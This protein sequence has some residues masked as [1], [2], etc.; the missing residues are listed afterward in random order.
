M[1]GTDVA[2][3]IR[4]TFLAFFSRVF[5]RTLDID[6]QVDAS[7]NEDYVY[8]DARLLHE[9]GSHRIADLRNTPRRIRIGSRY[10]R[11][12]HKNLHTLRQLADWDPTFDP[13][14]GFAFYEKDVPEIL[15]YLRSKASVRFSQRAEQISVENRPLEYVHDVR[16]TAEG[17]GIVTSLSDPD[18][19]VRIENIDQAKFLEGSKFV[20]AK[21][22]YFRNPPKKE[23]KTFQPT[24]GT[25]NL[26]GDQIPLFLLYDLKKLR[27]ETT[28]RISP[29]VEAQRVAADPFEAKVSLHVDGPWIW[30]DVRYQADRFKIPYGQVGSLPPRQQ[31]MR[32]EEVWVQVDRKTHQNVAAQFDQIPEVERVEGQF[33]TPT[34]HFNEVQSL[35][36][37]VA[38]LDL[39]EAY[40][41]FMKSLEDFTQ[42]QE[43]P[44]PYGF[45]GE[46]RGYQ[47]HG[48]DWLCFLRHYGLN[49]ILA[50]EMGLGKTVQAL[51]GL[52]ESHSLPQ[53]GT[54][55]IV[56]PPTV[57]SAWEEEIR[58]FISPVDFSIARY[59]GANRKA[60]LSSL[61]HYDAI[62]TTYNIVVRDI[63]ALA[64]VAWEYVI[65][66][67]A[68][69]IKNHETATANAC[70]RLIARHKLALT[71][72]PI[73]NRLS[74][75]W[76]I[77][78]FLMPSYLGGQSQ[79]RDKYEVPIMKYSDKRAAT[80]L[81]R[82]IG[83][84]K[85]RRLK[86]QVAS[87]LPPKIPM[88]RYCEL[89]PEQ[90]HLYKQF[91]AA[92]SEKIRNL[93][94][95]TIRIDTSILTA[96]LR[97]KQICC[98]PALV[99]GDREKIHGRSGKLEA[100]LEILDELTENG[101]KALIFSQ[102]TEMLAILRQVLDEKGVSYFYLD[103][104]TPEKNR[105]RM[106]EDFQRGALPFFL[107]S[108]RAGGLGLTLTEAN[109]VVHY[110]RWWN[111][112]VEDQATDRVHRI[113]QSKP[114]KVFRIH[115]LGTIEERIGELLVKKKDLF[116]SV[117]EADDLRKEISKDELLALFAP[118]N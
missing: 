60:V 73:E 52:L 41:T 86:S 113:G 2:H 79:F 83:P 4:D 82:R 87:E 118:P 63:D 117:I 99:L 23:Y 47:K 72:T 84:F 11:I 62:L 50:D 45:R 111:P 35:L 74:E 106:K 8:V 24:P 91:A 22:G 18:S 116:D 61:G 71:G 17:L 107:I 75:L 12:S 76:S 7:P 88:D 20:H 42:I 36:G 64:N 96:I 30:F 5:P 49:G 48:Y 21:A 26:V 93:P 46:L 53:A 81:K 112:A 54:S 92:E 109:C 67:E 105:S 108:L 80:E 95:T 19:K 15:N 31:F 16:E 43:Q 9:S 55:L 114:V 97:L 27:A 115:T 25:A 110:D 33:R 44:L 51:V 34:R 29:G 103:G 85:L 90:V 6:V 70:K 40:G 102:F 68:Q 13:R 3:R 104:A 101:E 38:K 58:K 78:D 65:L 28:A 57:L 1:A 69:K 89:T 39:S 100:F 66:D 37:K 10:V 94:G 56:C 77:Y 59:V 98:H 14:K 32:E